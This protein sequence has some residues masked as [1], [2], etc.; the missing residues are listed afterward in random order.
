MRMSR[1]VKITV[2]YGSGDQGKNGFIVLFSDYSFISRFMNVLTYSLWVTVCPE[3]IL[4]FYYSLLL[5]SDLI[6]PLA[7]LAVQY[8]LVARNND[9]SRKER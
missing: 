2:T 7:F 6:S 8:H 9:K 3:S 1:E 4:V 5:M